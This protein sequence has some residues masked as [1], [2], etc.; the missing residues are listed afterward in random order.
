M[1]SASPITPQ[2]RQDVRASLVCPL[3]VGPQDRGTWVRRNLLKMHLLAAVKAAARRIQ[4]DSY[5]C[6]P[7]AW[8]DRPSP[9]SQEVP[10]RPSVSSSRVPK[11]NSPTLQSAPDNPGVKTFLKSRVL[12]CKAIQP[13]HNSHGPS[14][15]LPLCSNRAPRLGAPDPVIAPSW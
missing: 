8:H 6:F 3:Y 9:G 14:Q 13:R 11:R 1:G 5:F 4:L 12:A 2:V 10:L 7:A 15:P